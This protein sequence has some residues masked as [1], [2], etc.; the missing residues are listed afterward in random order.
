MRKTTKKGKEVITTKVRVGVTLG[1]GRGTCSKRPLGASGWASKVLFLD[2]SVVT[3]VFILNHSSSFTFVYVLFK[4][5]C[6]LFYN[7]KVLKKRA[8]RR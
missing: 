7:K 4:K 1:A 5:T 2:L 8:T 3:K 6:V